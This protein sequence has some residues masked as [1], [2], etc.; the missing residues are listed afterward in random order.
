MPFRN[1][2][3]PVPD[4]EFPKTDLQVRARPT[5]GEFMA[6]TRQHVP[7]AVTDNP[8]SH[9]AGALS[10]VNPELQKFIKY[11]HDNRTAEE[12]A[13]AFVAAQNAQAVNVRDL[14]EAQ[15][16]GLIPD[17]ASPNFIRAWK[18]NVLKLDGERAANDW[19]ADYYKNDDV[20]NSEDPKVF[21]KFMA[22]WKEKRTASLLQKDGQDQFTAME[23][24][25]SDYFKILQQT[26]HQIQG[27]HL[28]FRVAERERL[29]AETVGNLIQVRLDA[30]FDNAVDP[31]NHAEVAAQLSD[32]FRNKVTGLMEYGGIRG[33]KANE[34]LT[35]NLV[36][37][38]IAAGDPTI[39]EIAKHIGPDEKASLWNTQVFREKAE[40]ARQHIANTRFHD[41]ERARK[42]AEYR[43]LGIE[44]VEAVEE[45]ARQDRA[46]IEEQYISERKH[47]EQHAKSIERHEAVEPELKAIMALHSIGGDVSS[48][49]IRRHLQEILVADPAT[50]QSLTTW[51]QTQARHGKVVDEHAALMTY[52]RL[53]AELSTDPGKFDSRKILKEANA[54]LLTASQVGELFNHVDSEKK[55]YRDYPL[56]STPLV[57]DLRSNLRGSVQSNP[58]DEFGEGRLRADK[59]TAELNGL[60]VGYLKSHP[61]ASEWD[62]YTAIQP[63]IE[64]I[65]R[66]HS[67]DLNEAL[68]AKERHSA[69]ASP[70][71]R[72]ELDAQLKQRYPNKAQ[73]DAVIEQLLRK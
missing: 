27:E 37:K 23:V 49:E 71:R 58:L 42:R 51:L 9:L 12:V 52:S 15:H 2:M 64:N 10:A 70:N 26:E 67:P 4:A 16:R 57:N 40:A 17:G 32:V 25:G 45:R 7:D 60:I 18:S 41:E 56:L 35:T 62:V 11:V 50:Y 48:P 8:L 63:M 68:G 43:G 5:Q 53:R 72:A 54:G 14:K 73:R 20:R 55:N 47:R 66:K 38:A 39:L 31:P 44:S 34:I 24:Y 1:H 65:A 29:A 69:P 59:A 36:T 46:R 22:E 30:A 21:D 3:L 19:R 28:T 6:P 61:K 13:A 33:S